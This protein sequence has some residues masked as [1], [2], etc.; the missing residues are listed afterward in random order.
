MQILATEA[1][2]YTD[3]SPCIMCNNFEK[4]LLELKA[5]NLKEQALTD[6]SYITNKENGSQST[7]AEV[8]HPQSTKKPQ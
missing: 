5:L 4:C 6:G 8:Y 2:H 1:I 3:R 7:G